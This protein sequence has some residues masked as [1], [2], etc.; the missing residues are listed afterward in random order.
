MLITIDITGKAFIRKWIAIIILTCASTYSST[1]SFYSSITNSLDKETS[2]NKV[3]RNKH[4]E[5]KS[6][7]YSPLKARKE[8]L[9]YRF[10]HSTDQKKRLTSG[11][12]EYKKFNE[13]AYELGVRVNELKYYLD[14]NSEWFEKEET[15]LIVLSPT[16]IHDKDQ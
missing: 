16:A 6:L 8:D 2:F 11:T 7:I 15:D 1:Y 10:N 12:K 9:E 3:A 4:K 13:E 5:L 14:I